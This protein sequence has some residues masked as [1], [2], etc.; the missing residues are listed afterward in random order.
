[1]GAAKENER[2]QNIFVR[3]LGIH[4]ILLSEEEHMGRVFCRE[5]VFI[6]G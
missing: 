4:E 2:C 6:S 5:R 3:S 1:M